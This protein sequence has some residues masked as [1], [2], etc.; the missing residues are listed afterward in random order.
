MYKQI[1]KTNKVVH[2]IR[3][4]IMQLITIYQSMD[5]KSNFNK[6]FLRKC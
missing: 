2:S 3:G 6:Y 4:S 1:S 5:V